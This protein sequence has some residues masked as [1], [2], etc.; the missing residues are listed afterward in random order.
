[1]RP[2]NAR[3][4][5]VLSSSALG[6]RGPV[7]DLNFLTKGIDPRITFTRSTVAQYFDATGIMRQAAVNVPRL[8]YGPVPTG[9]TNFIRN[10]V[11]AGAVVGTPGTPPTSWTLPV[12]S[13]VLTTSSITG[14]GVENGI[15]YC[16]FSFATA[17]AGAFEVQFDSGN[18]PASL[19]QTW[20]GSANYRLTGGSNTNVAH[21]LVQ[22]EQGGTTTSGSTTIVPTS[23]SLDTQ[24]SSNTKTNVSEGTSAQ[25]FRYNFSTS[26]AAA[27]TIRLG[28]PQFELSASANPWIA[29][30]G[31]VATLGATPLGLLIEEARTNGIRN[32][33]AEG[34]V[35]GSPG[36]APTNWSFS[37]A[38][39]TVTI[40]GT[41]VETGI[42]YVDVQLSG[43]AAETLGWGFEGTQVIAALQGQ[44]WSE[45]FYCRLVAGALAGT[46]VQN[47]IMPTTATGTNLTQTVATIVPTSAPLA[48][49]RTALT[50]TLPDAT[51]AFVHPRIRIST[52]ASAFNFTLRIAAPQIE[53]GS[54]ATSLM[55]PTAGT[56]AASSRTIETAVINFPAP[57]V[58]P[59]GNAIGKQ[60]GWAANFIPEGIAGTNVRIVGDSGNTTEGPIVLNSN[61]AGGTYDGVAE[62]IT[63][64]FTTLGALTKIAASLNGT[65]GAV[66]MNGGTVATSSGMTQGY[67][68]MTGIR[69]MGSGGT[70]D[71]NGWMQRLRFWK[72]S[73]SNSEL[74]QLS[75]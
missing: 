39:T 68:A 3:T 32:P 53:L 74:Q 31:A 26:G 5:A 44:I 6:S 20:T 29:T 14:F 2:G 72:R 7:L 55:L 60:C 51:T 37:T 61:L 65:A 45:S 69:I 12:V 27:W 49:Q 62:P 75:T 10:S 59:L 22:Y 11:A 28:A 18:A 30:S 63:P 25:S 67:G 23:A 17:S 58:S 36:T 47:C 43:S 8:D 64:N 4:A 38:L 56:P 70:L 52:P 33:R 34:V 66:A 9:V 50:Y 48:T 73:L 35:N 13:A 41:G 46:V 42:P 40:V 24:R 16:E 21:H 15:P 57:I 71:A 54:F 1:M 19:G